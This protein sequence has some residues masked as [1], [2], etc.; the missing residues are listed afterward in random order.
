MTGQVQ[1]ALAHDAQ[2]LNR[3]QYAMAK[4][5]LV[6]MANGTAPQKAY[7]QQ[8][9]GNPGAAAAS[10]AVALVGSVN[11]TS[12]NTFINPD[13]S[14]TTDA[15]DGAIESQVDTLWNAFSGV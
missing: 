14:V 8:V 10:M 3:V 1:M 2:F 6:K 13:L 5:A 12:V 4:V 11:L 15:T 7:A 9:L